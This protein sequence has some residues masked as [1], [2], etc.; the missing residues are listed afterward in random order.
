MCYYS[1]VY[2]LENAEMTPELCDDLIN[3]S[4]DYLWDFS[5]PK[6]HNSVYVNV[7]YFCPAFLECLKRLVCRHIY[8]CILR[9]FI[10]CCSRH[11]KWITC[12]GFFRLTLIGTSVMSWKS[13]ILVQDSLYFWEVSSS[14]S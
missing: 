11:L 2:H 7:R 10:L 1:T 3:F 14:L 12:P 5:K 4:F 8:L 13:I 9:I 6:V